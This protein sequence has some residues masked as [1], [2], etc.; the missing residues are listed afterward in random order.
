MERIVGPLLALT[1]CLSRPPVAPPPRIDVQGDADLSRVASAMARLPKVTCW[2][3]TPETAEERWENLTT[4]PPSTYFHVAVYN[5]LL[6]IV[7]RCRK[8]NAPAQP[9]E[10]APPTR[11][12]RARDP[13]CQ[14]YVEAAI[15]EADRFEAFGV[16]EGV[17]VW[18]GRADRLA[19]RHTC[20]A[21]APT[22]CD[23]LGGRASLLLERSIAAE[24]P[25]KH[26]YSIPGMNVEASGSVGCPPLCVPLEDGPKLSQS[27]EAAYAPSGA[28]VKGSYEAL[29]DAL[30]RCRHLARG[31]DTSVFAL[32]WHTWDDPNRWF[33]GGDWPRATPLSQCVVEALD[34]PRW[35]SVEVRDTEKGVSVYAEISP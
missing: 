7:E 3:D 2:F 1:G 13:S 23:C 22:S 9:E 34:D 32:H 10:S 28:P 33:L 8:R 35:I 20:S 27:S 17:D 24:F 25:L 26:P 18:L 15:G 14:P 29:V 11:M 12:L 19:D 16:D 4:A 21:S 5:N 31:A 6:S 30:T